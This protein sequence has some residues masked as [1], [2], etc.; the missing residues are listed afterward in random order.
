MTWILVLNMIGLVLAASFVL[1]SLRQKP[2]WPRPGK[3]ASPR[4]RRWIG[5]A[6]LLI[7]S[8]N[9]V[10]WLNMTDVTNLGLLA[11]GLI[12][13]GLVVLIAGVAKGPTDEERERREL[14][15]SREGN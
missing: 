10:N 13:L 15:L 14:M 6:L 4:Q 5:F 2:M 8:G 7:M 11:F 3:S 9:T 1:E 12:L